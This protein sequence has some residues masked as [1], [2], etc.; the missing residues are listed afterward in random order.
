MKL[1]TA[2]TIQFLIAEKLERLNGDIRAYQTTFKDAPGASEIVAS[3]T[4]RCEELLDAKADFEMIPCAIGQP[5][6][7]EI[8][9]ISRLERGLK[10]EVDQMI[11]SNQYSYRDI[12]SFLAEHG[13]NTSISS[14]SRYAKSKSN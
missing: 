5:R 9:L 10:D 11:I 4:H 8:G 6:R 7:K 2:E 1:D 13:V 3:L 14:I 12:V